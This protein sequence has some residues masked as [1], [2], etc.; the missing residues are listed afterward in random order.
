MS[1]PKNTRPFGTPRW[2][3]FIILMLVLLT[4]GLAVGHAHPVDNDSS[5]SPPSGIWYQYW[6]FT[7]VC[8][9]KDVSRRSKTLMILTNSQQ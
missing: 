7:L 1:E 8:G 4:G 3:F 5:A 6:K 9:S 2:K